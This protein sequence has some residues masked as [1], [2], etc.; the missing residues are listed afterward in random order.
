LLLVAALCGCK[1]R[2]TI[3]LDFDLQGSSCLPFSSDYWTTGS[4]TESRCDGATVH[5]DHYV[6]Y[7]E[8]DTECQ[9]CPCGGCV[10][11]GTKTARACPDDSGNPCNDVDA[12]HG[13]ELDLS[14]GLWAVVLEAYASGSLPCL[15]A[16]QCIQI[17][18]DTN[19]VASS[20]PGLPEMDGCSVCAM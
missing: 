4:G 8:A 1:S 15:V 14:P 13:R 16:N 18:V 11:A 9:N 5:I 20:T 7:A 2:G 17:T 10:G 12:V 19:G 6:L 3:T